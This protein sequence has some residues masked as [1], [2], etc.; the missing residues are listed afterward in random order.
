MVVAAAAVAYAL[1]STSL[2]IDESTM[3]TIRDVFACEAC[4]LLRVEA[5]SFLE[6]ETF[7]SAV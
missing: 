7:Q 3:A 4:E 5:V 6:T 1:A 2:G